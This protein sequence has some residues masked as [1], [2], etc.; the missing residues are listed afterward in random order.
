VFIV[1]SYHTNEIYRRESE[2]LAASLRKLGIEHDIV[3]LPDRGS[4]EKNVHGKP[5]FILK[6]LEGHPGH[7]VLWLDSDAIVRSDPV[8]FRT[9]GDWQF[10]AYR[11]V[12]DAFWGG[13]LYFR[14][15]PLV[16]QAVAWWSWWTAQNPRKSDELSLS[17]AVL[18]HGLKILDLTMEYC[19]VDRFMKNAWPWK[20]PIIEHA[21][22][23]HPYGVQRWM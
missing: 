19:W 9:D 16:R 17:A 18:K 7:D 13:T 5:D 6:M 21:T 14:N 3:A 1:A 11:R 15:D 10:A 20:V 12:K 4:W 22:V 2:K 23:G 8:M